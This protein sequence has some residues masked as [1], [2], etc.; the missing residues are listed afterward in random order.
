MQ[1]LQFLVP[2]GPLEAVADLIPHVVLVLVL[3]NMVTRYLGHEAHLRQAEDGGDEA[4]SRYVPHTVTSVLLV[5]AT[6]AF[7]I[8]EP[9]GGMVMTVLVIG[10]FLA[11][12][13]ELEAREVEARNDM[14]I[15]PPKSALAASVLALVYAA[16][17]SIFFVVAPVWNAVV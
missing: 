12:F 11:D 1:P 8:V 14:P 17:Q 16:F 10:V 7:M 13:F 5:L 15:E 9:H 3:A 6:F 4:I 2:L